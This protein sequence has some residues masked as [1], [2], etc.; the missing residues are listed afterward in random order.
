[1]RTVRGGHANLARDLTDRYLAYEPQ[2]RI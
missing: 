2:P 1:V